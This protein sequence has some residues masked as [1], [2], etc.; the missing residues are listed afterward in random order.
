MNFER[1]LIEYVILILIYI[2]VMVSIHANI[3]L[4]RERERERERERNLGG[5]H[6][7]IGNISLTLRLI[8]ESDR[9]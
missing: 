9:S 8:L 2:M 4:R 6:D 1:N 7:L 3:I 5:D